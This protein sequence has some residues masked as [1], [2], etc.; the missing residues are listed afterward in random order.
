LQSHIIFASLLNPALHRRI[1]FQLA[2]AAKTVFDRVSVL[3]NGK[4]EHV[5]CQDGIHVVQK[6]IFPRLS[7]HR[8]FRQW[9]WYKIITKLAPTH[10]CFATPELIPLMLYL[11]KTTGVKL[12]YDVQENY[13]RNILYG[14]DYPRLLRPILARQVRRLE[15]SAVPYLDGVIYAETGFDNILNVPAQRKIIIRNVY[16]PSGHECKL[17]LPPKPYLLITGTLA[18]EWGILEAIEAYKI[19]VS[20]TDCYLI[21]AGFGNNKNFLQ[22]IK[23]AVK[24]YS[25]ILVEGLTNTVSYPRIEQLIQN[26]IAGFAL[27]QPS[28]RMADRIPTKFYE[29]AAYGKPLI[30]SD[31][32]PWNDLNEQYH[33]GIPVIYNNPKIVAERVN[34]ILQNDL[35]VFQSEPKFYS[36]EFEKDKWIDWLGQIRDK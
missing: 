2:R 21:I 23:T 22:K 1:F 24:G 34:H 28:L 8:L 25:S 15:R 33:L 31:F 20:Q 32:D 3:G 6:M 12:I 26:C 19:I 10:I 29:Y 4:E 16:A 18:P 13:E 17:P 36:W 14:S 9:Q 5:Y 35:S 30:F 27:Y 11:K 7:V